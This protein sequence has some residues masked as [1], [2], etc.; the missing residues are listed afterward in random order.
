MTTN[1]P[2]KASLPSVLPYQAPTSNGQDALTGQFE[3]FLKG[4]KSLS[5]QTIKNYV[6]DIDI[7]LDWLKLS[8]QEDNLTP[9]HITAARVIS[10]SDYL[11]NSRQTLNTKNR[12]LSSLRRFGHFLFTTKLSD[13]NPAAHLVSAEAAFTSAHS[14]QI[15]TEFKHDLNKQNLSASTIKNYLSDVK[16]YFRWVENTQTPPK[17]TDNIQDSRK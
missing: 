3:Q 16:Q 11:N 12:H 2:P 6:S 4:T 7:F 13:L 15:L 8:L 14:S 17:I 1:L 9:A 5:D 10:Y